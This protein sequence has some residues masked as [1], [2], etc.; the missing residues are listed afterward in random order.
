M[1]VHQ[2]P[3]LDSRNL[4]ADGSGGLSGAGRHYVAGLLEHMAE[5]TLFG[6][7]TPNSYH[8]WA[9]HSFAPTGERAS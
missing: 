9:G 3:W 8:R 7:A 5:L 6:S 2:S 4:F 1:H